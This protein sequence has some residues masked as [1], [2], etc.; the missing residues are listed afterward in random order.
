[1]DGLFGDIMRMIGQQGPDAWFQNATQLALNVARGED[2]DPNP[3]PRERQRLEQ[4]APLVQRRIDSLFSVVTSPA[5]TA[6][7]RSTLTMAALTQWR[8]LLEPLTSQPPA[9]DL[10]EAEGGEMLAQIAGSFGPLFLGFQM[11]SVA[12]HF[13]ER[14][15]SLSALALPRDDAS[16]LIVANNLARFAKEW[17]LDADE[18]A[19]FA[20]AREFVASLVL[21]Q[22]GTGDALRALLVDAVRESAAAQGDIVSRL[23]GMINPDNVNSFM[24]NPEALLEQIELPGETAA[25]RAINAASAALGAFFDLAAQEITSSILGDR[26]A[27]VEAW[28]RHRLSDARGED[29]A[30]ALFGISNQGPHHEA[31]RAFVVEITAAHSLSALGAFLRVDG[32]PSD[33]EL[34]DPTAWYQR[35]TNSPLA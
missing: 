7:T 6:V 4:F 35:V 11:G 34:S 13:S 22:P 1:M 16:R 12:G 25:T 15:W 5:V 17:S 28:R 19:V 27:L 33:A 23:Q 29:A 3:E 24:A 9:L 8:P 20:L 31:A 18:V 2:G 26:S 21:T 14:A 32:L 30:A 10:S